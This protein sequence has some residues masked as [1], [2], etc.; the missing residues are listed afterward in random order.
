MAKGN[1]IRVSDVE[2][3]YVKLHAL[4]IM[5]DRLQPLQKREAG[6]TAM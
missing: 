3:L 1:N 6:V 5:L 4:M 2:T